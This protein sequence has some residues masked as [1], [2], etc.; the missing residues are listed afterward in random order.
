MHVLRLDNACSKTRQCM[1]CNGINSYLILMARS[2]AVFNQRRQCLVDKKCIWLI[3]VEAE[4]TEPAGRAATDT[5]QELQR[6][7]DDVVICLVALGA[8]EILQPHNANTSP[9][10]S[11]MSGLQIAYKW[12]NGSSNCCRSSKQMMVETF[13]SKALL[14]ST[15]MKDV[16]YIKQTC[17]QR[18]HCT[19]HF[20]R[21]SWHY[22]GIQHPFHKQHG[23][24][25]KL[26]LTLWTHNLGISG[27]LCIETTCIPGNLEWTH[28]II[29]YCPI[30]LVST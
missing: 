8:Q 4:E 22:S 24:T 14:I 15:K 21:E 1:L 3:D 30:I 17:Q 13:H 18:A 29:S 16:Y 11:W 26:N 7:T 19:I 10:S 27:C 6:L 25:V 2:L 12:Q 9:T 28:K 5:V 20:L 23:N